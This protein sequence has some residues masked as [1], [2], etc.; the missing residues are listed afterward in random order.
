MK[1]I[2]ALT[3]LIFLLPRVSLAQTSINAVYFGQTHVLKASDTN[4]GM[5]GN[6][7]ALIKVHVINPATPASPAVSATLTASGLPNLV[8]PLTGPATLPASIPD[9]PGVVQHS[10]A[11]SFT[12]YIPA[13]YMK[14]GLQVT[15]NAGMPPLKFAHIKEFRQRIFY[16]F[17]F[18]V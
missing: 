9:G 17:P 10:F 2:V 7:E 3:C 15:I 5:V 18:V 6:R 11:N 1:L 8:V 13:N 4:F 16:R 12:G 14:T